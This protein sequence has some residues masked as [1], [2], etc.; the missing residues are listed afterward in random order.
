MELFCAEQ[1]CNVVYF[2]EEQQVF[3]KSDFQV[4]VFKK[5]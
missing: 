4:A 2:N 5:I 3:M 1:E